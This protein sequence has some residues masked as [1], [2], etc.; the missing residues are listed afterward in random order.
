MQL[1]SHDERSDQD[2]YKKDLLKMK[3][4]DSRNIGNNV[5]V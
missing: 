4:Q 3:I 2:K 5:V 1:L